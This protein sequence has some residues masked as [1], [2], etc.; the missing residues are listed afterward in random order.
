MK[1][2]NTE[3]TKCGIWYLL[4]MLLM[5]SFT[6]NLFQHKQTSTSSKRFCTSDESFPSGLYLN[7]PQ[8]NKYFNKR[9]EILFFWRFRHLEI[10]LKQ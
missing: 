8:Q 1:Y 6:L 3:L 5:I 9:S 2:E 7:G 10:K 4:C